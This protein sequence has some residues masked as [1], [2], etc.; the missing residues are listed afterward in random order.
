[1]RP[2]I[3]IVLAAALAGCASTGSLT[4]PV[5]GVLDA[6]TGRTVAFEE[7]IDDLATVPMVFVGESHTNPEHHE[8]QHRIVEALSARNPAVLVGMEMLQRPYQEVLDEWTVDDRLEQGHVWVTALTLGGGSSDA[9]INA[10][11]RVIIRTVGGG[12]GYRIQAA[13]TALQSQAYPS[14]R[15]TGP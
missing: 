4:G 13:G 12:A 9:M 11:G 2:P 3:P 10:Q 1:M 8:I 5:E 7:M 14:V 15:Y 6:R